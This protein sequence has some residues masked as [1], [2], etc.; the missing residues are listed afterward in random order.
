MH[1]IRV[2]IRVLTLY[3]RTSVIFVIKLFSTYCWIN[4]NPHLTL[5]YPLK[6]SIISV[7]LRFMGFLVICNI[8]LLLVFSMFLL[9]YDFSDDAEIVNNNSSIFFGLL[10]VL[11]V[12]ALYYHIFYSIKHLVTKESISTG[13]SNFWVSL[14]KKGEKFFGDKFN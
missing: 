3:F 11:I 12:F 9:I 5:Y 1:K 6:S 7:F 2:V 13:Y 4:K 8:I 10:V 14:K